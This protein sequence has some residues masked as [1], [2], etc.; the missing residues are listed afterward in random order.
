MSASDLDRQTPWSRVRVEEKAAIFLYS[1]A[2]NASNS[3]LQ[4]RFQ[5]SGD[6][7]HR[8]H[9]YRVLDVV[10]NMASPYLVQPTTPSELLQNEPKYAGQFDQCRLAFDGT[11]IPAYVPSEK[12]KPF[13]DRTGKLSQNVFAACTF[14]MQFV[15]VLSGWEGSAADSTVLADA[16][17]KG[18][19]TPLGLFDLGDAGYGLTT[20]VMTPYRGVRYHL[21]EWGQSDERPQNYKELYNLRHAQAPNVIERAFGV[22]KRRFPILKQTPEYSVET[23]AKIVRAC[24]VLHNF[25][26]LQE[27]LP[28]D[29]E[30]ELEEEDSDDERP[31]TNYPERNTTGNYRR[32]SNLR[33]LLAKNMWDSYVAFQR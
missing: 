27:D 24:C 6:T 14:D 12:A 21:K 32:A 26:R 17:R 9:F 5:H 22:L 7:I 28:D 13:R 33:D 31:D 2:K 10:C 25:I 20:E 15:Y 29:P 8:R 1:I 3:D 11:H 16:R 18:F 19:R 30:G 4:E 23:Q